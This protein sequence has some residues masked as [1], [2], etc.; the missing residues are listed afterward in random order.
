MLKQERLEKLEKYIKQ[1]RYVSNQELMSQFGI[2]R[3]TVRRDLE[4]LCEKPEFRLTRGGVTYQPKEP[5]N[6]LPYDEKRGENREE[7]MSALYMKR[8]RE[9]YYKKG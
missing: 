8:M 5:G 2:S 4:S 6:E 7:K 9:S 3:A 1:H